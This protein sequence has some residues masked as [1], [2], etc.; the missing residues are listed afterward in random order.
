MFDY[1][2]SAHGIAVF[3]AG[4]MSPNATFRKSGK[5][6][7]AFSEH[8]GK[9]GFNRSKIYRHWIRY[10]KIILKCINFIH[11][12]AYNFIMNV[13]LG[14]TPGKRLKACRVAHGCKKL[15]AF[16]KLLDSEGFSISIKRL[17]NLESGEAK[18]DADDLEAI[19]HTLKITSDCILFGVCGLTI[20]HRIREL[21]HLN[22][23]QLM[24]YLKS[25]D[26][27]LDLIRKEI[28]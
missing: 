26:P 14:D 9:Q 27:L 20:A 22:D 16:K 7:G 5:N 25:T 3:T 23:R 18:F 19:T 4:K 13:D 10:K 15:P 28:R 24:F 11:L 1:S 21:H 2:R 6:R 17:R 8:R 12:I